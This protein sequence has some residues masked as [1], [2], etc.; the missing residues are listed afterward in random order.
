MGC[1]LSAIHEGQGLGHIVM[2]RLFPHVLGQ[3]LEVGTLNQG[4]TALGADLAPRG[5]RAATG[6][7]AS[8]LNIQELV[9]APCISP[10]P[11]LFPE[12][13]SVIHC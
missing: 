10:G 4:L 6:D 9:L 1:V 8:H 5:V 12:D 3:A 7:G 2:S 13:G 11:R